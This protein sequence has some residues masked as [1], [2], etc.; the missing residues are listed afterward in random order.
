[1][2]T[3]GRFAFQVP[4]MLAARRGVGVARAER[5][6]TRAGARP[7]AATAPA[8]GGALRGGDGS[9]LF[10]ALADAFTND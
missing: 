5:R 8:A 10:A 2:E 3:S 6:P 1:M 4:A 9:L 7:L